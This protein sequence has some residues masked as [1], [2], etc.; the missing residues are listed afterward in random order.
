MI[1]RCSAVWLCFETCMSMKNVCKVFVASWTPHVTVSVWFRLVCLVW[2]ASSE[3]SFPAEHVSTLFL[4]L[5][6][7]SH[8]GYIWEN[9]KPRLCG[10]SW[11][12]VLHFTDS[13]IN[14]SFLRPW[15]FGTTSLCFYSLLSRS[16]LT[17]TQKIKSTISNRV[18]FSFYIR[19]LSQIMFFFVFWFYISFMSVPCDAPDSTICIYHRFEEYFIQRSIQDSHKN[20]AEFIPHR[21]D[22]HT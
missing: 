20:H 9:A 10:H 19:I 4:C 13:S 17:C 22:I 3:A 12:F 16:H 18:S 6:V 1:R 2:C 21:E 7:N 5:L 15:S 8:L 14:S 11:R